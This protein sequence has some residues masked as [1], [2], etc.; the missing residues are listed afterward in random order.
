[1]WY[2]IQVRSGSEIKIMNFCREFL[3]YEGEECFI[4]TVVRRKRIRGEWQ[5]VETKLFPGYLFFD[6]QDC[7]DLYFRLKKITELTKILK[8]ADRFAPLPAHEDR[9]LD[10]MLGKN[11]VLEMSEG[12][13]VG[14]EV[15]IS[16][17]PLSQLSGSI[18]KIDRHKRTAYV[19]IEFMGEKKTIKAGLEI[20]DKITK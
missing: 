9:I 6:T 1:M 20:V 12:I 10:R 16:T 5:N 13:I 14:D 15:R 17:G 11:H 3:K 4:P 18:K 7:E 19:E 8:S 2:V